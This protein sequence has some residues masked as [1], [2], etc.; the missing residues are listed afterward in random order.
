MEFSSDYRVIFQAKGPKLDRFS[1]R[2]I[3]A[4]Y[5]VLEAWSFITVYDTLNLN[6]R[7]KELNKQFHLQNGICVY[8]L[9]T[10][11]NC[12]IINALKLALIIRL[13]HAS[14]KWAKTECCNTNQGNGIGKDNTINRYNSIKVTTTLMSE[15]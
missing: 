13:L 1:C 15:L 14:R 12:K 4:R 6:I 10:P 11:C 8:T 5:Y 9:T 3:S 2:R 7:D